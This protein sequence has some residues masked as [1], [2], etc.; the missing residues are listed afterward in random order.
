[1]SKTTATLSAQVA[2][3]LRGALHTEL[4]RACE[5]AP[6]IRPESVARAAWTPVLRRINAAFRSLDV[7]GW[8]EPEEQQPVTITLDREMI[9]ALEMDADHWGWASEQVRTESAEGRERAAEH[10]AAI[11]RFL[12]SLAERPVSLMIP[13]AAMPLVRE[14]AH[15]GIP[16]LSEAIERGTDL[17]ECCRRLSAI[18]D[19]L[20]VIGWSENE[21][22]SEDVDAT[23]HAS[24]VKELTPPI[25][26]TLRT[27]VAELDHGDP[28]KPKVE[29]ELRLL[30]QLH[31]QASEALSA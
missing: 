9:E 4:A 21:E 11:E 2:V 10:A 15:E 13:M 27:A 23:E 7:I 6:Q 30:S 16:T 29:A 22:P 26:E 31:T 8:G 24:T 14:C 28:K 17:R 25:M 12:A 18:C 19:L 5:D 1:M 3:L 20:D